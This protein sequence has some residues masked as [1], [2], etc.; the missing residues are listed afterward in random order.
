VALDEQRQSVLETR[1]AKHPA[2]TEAT[3][4]SYFKNIEDS[5]E[6]TRL[7]ELL[8]LPDTGH[9]VAAGALLDHVGVRGLRVGDAAVYEKHANIIVNRGRATAADVLSLGEA[10]RGKVEAVFGVRLEREVIWMGRDAPEVLEMS[11]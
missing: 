1:A 8:A 9:R 11:L 3:A 7:S 5:N 6:R 10:M 4:G 2:K